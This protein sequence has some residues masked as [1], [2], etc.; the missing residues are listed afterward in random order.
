[1]Q[2]L[3][4]TALDFA[5]RHLFEVRQ[6]YTD[7]HN[8]TLH[9]SGDAHMTSSELLA[10]AKAKG[11]SAV[12]I[13]EH[14]DFD[15]PHKLDTQLL[16]DVDAYF[17]SFWKWAADVPDGLNL[18]SGIELGYQIHLCDMY[19][20]LVQSHPFDS[21][22]MSNHLYKGQDPYFFRQCYSSP[23]TQVYSGYIDELTKMVLSSNEF[24][25]VGHYDYIMRYAPYDDQTMKY[26]DSPDS[27]DRFLKAIISR[28]KS[29]EINTRSIN[30]L[31]AKNSPDF[32][33]D[34]EIL[35]RYLSL[36]GKRI[37]LGS[38]SH[39][40]TTVGFYFDETAAYLKDIGF[41]YLTSYVG[42]KEIRTSIL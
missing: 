9:F 16:F 32:M 33:P 40:P 29:L 23:K 2:T 12:V 39:D 15:Y 36:G 1:M 6:L 22:I 10:G 26:K 41:S 8:H 7:S 17:E 37:T 28:G 31:I 20:K 24:D 4:S 34:Q 21:V 5:V 27:F 38:D 42:R 14:Y 25:I 11:L 18:F 35:E 30:N 19:D 13:T 3:T